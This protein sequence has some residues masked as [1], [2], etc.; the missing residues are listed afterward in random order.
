[1]SFALS[2]RASIVADEI[3]NLRC[4]Q[5][6]VQNFTGVLSVTSVLFVPF[7]YEYTNIAQD[8]S[9]VPG[10]LYKLRFIFAIY[11]IP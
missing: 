10:R 8:D 7:V 6:E 5:C 4:W 11:D 2:P 1:M 9:P 3:N